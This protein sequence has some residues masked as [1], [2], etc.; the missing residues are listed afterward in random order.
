ML[1][2]QSTMTV[3]TL[4]SQETRT[5]MISRKDV[6]P[7]KKIFFPPP[8][9]PSLLQ[10]ICVDAAKPKLVVEGLSSTDLNQGQLVCG[11]LL[12]S[13]PRKET[14]GKSTPRLERPG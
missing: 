3:T 6:S 12:S 8:P 5:L 4:P 11:G 7:F 14:L 1:S 9:P 10:E 13:L 2:Q